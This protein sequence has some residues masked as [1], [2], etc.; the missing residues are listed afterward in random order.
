MKQKQQ[1]SKKIH[2]ELAALRSG[3]IETADLLEELAHYGL[4][5]VV[6]QILEAEV[7]DHLGRGWYQHAG[8]DE[9]RKGY[10][11]GYER[12]ILKTRMGRVAIEKPRLRGTKEPFRSA[13]WK[14]LSGLGYR[15]AQLGIEMYIRGL[16]TRDIEQTLVT[17]EQGQ[18]KPL[19]TRS[20]MSRLS[21]RLTQEYEAFLRRDLSEFDVVY[22]FVDGVYESVR[23]YTNGQ[24]ILAAWAIL[25]NGKK[26]LLH[27]A[28]VQSESEAAWT[29]FF[30]EM[31]TRGLRHPLMITS[32][33]NKGLTAAI[34]R[35]FPHADRQRCI[36]HKMRNLVSKMPK[37]KT[38][39]TTLTGELKAIFYATDRTTADALH[40]QFVERYAAI[41]PAVVRCLNDDI[42][43]CLNHLKYPA[44]HQ[45]F[46]RTTNLLE[47]CFEE[48][49]RRTKIIPT[50]PNER[51]AMKLVFGV[52]LRVSQ[53]WNRVSM[54]ENEL[55][56]LRNVRQL[57][58]H[59]ENTNYIS[60]RV[61][62]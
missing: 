29:G 27:L 22:L 40:A 50:H 49:K 37:E 35:A 58:N 61:A 36:V 32:D 23:K 52:L 6:Q 47:R 14:R 9:P 19:L 45:K 20:V 60:Y 16:S 59:S 18:E 43:A 56:L 1:P 8:A 55:I 34:A 33:G 51:A 30:D 54:T 25:S 12:R 10:R 62:A 7:D 26:E 41:Y 57:K 31:F 17:V 44:G 5:S 38:I 13:L 2:E 11:N 53:R 15:L 21:E 3:R 42:E 48:E 4:R 39:V 24:T 46:I 28:A